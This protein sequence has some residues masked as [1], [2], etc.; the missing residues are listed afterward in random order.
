[1]KKLVLA[2]ALI[3]AIAAP[4]V[5]IAADVLTPEAADTLAFMREEEKLAH[6]VYALFET[7]YPA[8]APGAN[9]FGRL[10]ESESRHTEAVRKLLVTYGLTDPAQPEPG[11][12]L[13]A[14]LQ[15]LYDSLAAS[16]SQGLAQALAVGVVI[17]EKDITDLV[18]AIE[19]SVAYADI[20]QVY[21]NL[22]SGSESHLAAFLKTLARPS[23][24][25]K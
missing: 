9:V 18:A 25:K 5:V 2:L 11:V 7:L 6:D 10:A 23:L 14:D 4:P 20:V 8:S 19:V 22:L 13:N 16:G 15:A 3:G 21:S 17:E 1:M 24:T 12:F